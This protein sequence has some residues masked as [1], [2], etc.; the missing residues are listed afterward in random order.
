MA[1]VGSQRHRKQ[2]NYQYIPIVQPT[3][4]TSY[5][6][7]F[8]LVKRSTCFGRSF[9]PSSGARNWVY[10]NDICQTAAVAIGDEMELR[11]ISSPKAFYKNK[12]FEITGSSCLL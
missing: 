3:I 6:K 8:I 5:L 1:R 2:T 11:S 10:S 9:R 12:Y 4:C 7:L